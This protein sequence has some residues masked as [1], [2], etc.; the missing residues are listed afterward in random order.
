MQNN[1]RIKFK[2]ILLITL[3]IIILTTS[4]YGCESISSMIQSFK[5]D[6]I[7]NS[8][9]IR[10]YDN[11]GNKTMEVYGNK[12]SIEGGT[13]ESGEKSSYIDITIDG[14][15]WNHVG[16]TLVFMQDGVDM[17][18][19]FESLGTIESSSGSSGLMAV[20]KF[21]NS[22][23]NKIGRERVVI[24]SSQTGTPICMFQGDSCYT[25]V[26]DNLP[27][28]TKLSIDGKLVYVYRASIDIISADLLK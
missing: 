26:P 7:G 24:V 25:E 4:A 11:F 13:D 2:A 17:V 3:S 9:T 5:G 12:I 16:S 22:Y 28:T 23:K 21:I 27:T 15:E 19:D 8:Y 18:T 10:G 20:D 6:L 1:K 14:G